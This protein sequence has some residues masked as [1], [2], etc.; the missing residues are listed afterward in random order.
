MIKLM[1]YQIILLILVVSAWAQ[2]SEP[3]AQMK[4]AGPRFGFTVITGEAAETMKDEYDL[5]PFITQFGWQTETRFFSVPE[6]PTGV[7]EAIILL[8]GM[9]QSVVLPSL[10]LVVGLRRADGAE[11]GFGPNLSLSGIAY[12]IGGGFTRSAGQLNIPVNV[13]LV[14][15]DAGPRISLLVGFN[16]AMP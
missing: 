1:S 9:E 16:T 7:V 6:G 14:L 13:S 3:Q 11:I 10:S 5:N 12:V 2:S 8:G 4:L 15:S